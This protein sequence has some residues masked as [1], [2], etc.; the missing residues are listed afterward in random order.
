MN[1]D[2]E[3][4]YQKGSEMPA[5][6]LSRNLSS[7]HDLIPDGEIAQAQQGDPH[8]KAILAYLKHGTIPPDKAMRYLITR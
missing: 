5:D 2:F 7:I 6:Y 1:Y 8:L 3:I 4:H